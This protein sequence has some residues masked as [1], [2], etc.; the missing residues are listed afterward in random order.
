MA[1]LLGSHA[2]ARSY[3]LAGIETLLEAFMIAV[4]IGIMQ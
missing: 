1:I 3:Y 4:L 2:P